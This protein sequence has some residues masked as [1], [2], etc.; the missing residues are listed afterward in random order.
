MGALGAML[1]GR[2]KKADDAALREELRALSRTLDQNLA[3][4]RKEASENLHRQFQLVFDNQRLAGKEQN[5][6]LQ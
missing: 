1:F 4:A 6:A 2:R 3:D 5:E